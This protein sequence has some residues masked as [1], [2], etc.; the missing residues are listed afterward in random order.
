MQTPSMKR[1]LNLADARGQR[2]SIENRITEVGQASMVRPVT[3][4]PGPRD[5]HKGKP[6]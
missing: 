1:K 2:H 4:T 3:P 6:S 5:L